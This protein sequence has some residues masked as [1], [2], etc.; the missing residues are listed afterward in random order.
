MI[1][2]EGAMMKILN[3]DDVTVIKTVSNEEYEA[4]KRLI[5]EILNG[6]LCELIDLKGLIDIDNRT[7]VRVLKV[8]SDLM[9]SVS[10][11]YYGRYYK[12]RTV[13]KFFE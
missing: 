4:D 10:D 11:D 3:I 8:G 6:L 9:I 13:D 7:V 12:E 5:E 1:K 2:G